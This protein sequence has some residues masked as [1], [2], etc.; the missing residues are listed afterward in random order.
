MAMR[1][2]PANE[3]KGEATVRALEASNVCHLSGTECERADRA[4]SEVM[5]HTIATAWVLTACLEVG[6]LCLLRKVRELRTSLT[7]PTKTDRLNS[8]YVFKICTYSI[9]ILH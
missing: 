2:L 9:V 8:Q 4:S 1:C 5:L 6:E 3:V 7:R